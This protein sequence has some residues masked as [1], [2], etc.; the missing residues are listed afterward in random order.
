MVDVEV[1]V[2][3]SVVVV[4]MVVSALLDLV[5][6]ILIVCGRVRMLYLVSYLLKRSKLVLY[7][8]FTRHEFSNVVKTTIQKELNIRF[9]SSEVIEEAMCFHLQ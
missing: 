4:A 6:F 3:V 5:T 7:R 8:K 9:T 1:V 2:S